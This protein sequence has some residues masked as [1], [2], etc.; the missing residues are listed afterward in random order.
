MPHKGASSQCHNQQVLAKPC[1]QPSIEI[2][3]QEKNYSKKQK[4]KAERAFNLEKR[5]YTLYIEHSNQIHWSFSIY[6][7]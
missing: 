7:H 2:N 6:W 3:K 1:H 5:H 4:L